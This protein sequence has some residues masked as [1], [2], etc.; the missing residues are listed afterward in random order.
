LVAAPINRFEADMSIF[1]EIT[2]IVIVMHFH[3]PPK[4]SAQSTTRLYGHPT[5]STATPSDKICRLSSQIYPEHR[6]TS[7]NALPHAKPRFQC[8]NSE[9]HLPLSTTRRRRQQFEEEKPRFFI[10][11][12]RS[13]GL[14][15][16]RA[17]KRFHTPLRTTY[18][19]ILVE[20]T[21][22][23]TVHRAQSM[24]AVAPL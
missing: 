3:A 23:T 5:T 20:L 24:L 6:H 1:A 22:S 8:L 2:A 21:K 17:Q 15:P 18:K 11:V 19:K 10:R 13:T 16:P 9:L 12:N 7:T 14:P 4:N